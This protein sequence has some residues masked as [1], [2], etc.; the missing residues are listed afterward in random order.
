MPESGA[1]R[2][3]FFQDYFEDEVSANAFDAYD[4]FAGAPYQDLIDLKDRMDRQKLIDW[5]KDPETAI[6]RRRLYFT[7]L[8][9]CGTVAEAD[10][11]EK[12]VIDGGSPTL[13]GL[14]ALLAAYLCLKGESGVPLVEN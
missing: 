2:L 7:M 6:N 10:E 11:I 3:A 13:R 4:E 9:V 1:D 14:D 5:V 8:G 12:M